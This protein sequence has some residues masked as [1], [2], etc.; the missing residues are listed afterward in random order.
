MFSCPEGVNVEHC[1]NMA[2]PSVCASLLSPCLLQS[3]QPSRQTHGSLTEA[4]SFFMDGSLRGRRGD[5]W[6][7]P[8][9]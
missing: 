7:P 2:C 4:A 3:C 6:R 1:G 9:T 5:L 8:I